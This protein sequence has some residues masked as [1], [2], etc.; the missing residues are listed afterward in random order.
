MM[1][2]FI[3]KGLPILIDIAYDITY[4]GFELSK[5]S[6][7]V[8]AK[9][10]VYKSQPW[11]SLG[12]I[13]PI[14]L[15][16]ICKKCSI[17]LSTNLFAIGADEPNELQTGAPAC[18]QRTTASTGGRAGEAGPGGRTIHGPAKVGPLYVE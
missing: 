7:G 6:W 9:Q 15:L 16:L 4:A 5:K 8:R 2:D 12:G 1:A 13:N 11:C 18:P 17:L 3:T 14:R 10:S